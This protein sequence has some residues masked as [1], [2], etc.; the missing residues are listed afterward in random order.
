[1]LVN[2]ELLS[3]LPDSH[4]SFHFFFGASAHEEPDLFDCVGF[5]QVSIHFVLLILF[6]SVEHTSLKLV[7]LE[8]D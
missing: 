3:E 1:M 4:G 6:P 7:R 5:E 2:V 8:N